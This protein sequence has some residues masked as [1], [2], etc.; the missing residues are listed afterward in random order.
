MPASVDDAAMQTAEPRFSPLRI[1]VL[2]AGTA[3]TLFF[4]GAVVEWWMIPHDRRDG[5]ELIGLLL[6]L[7]YFL[8]LA[9]PTLLL[10]YIGRWLPFAAAL[11]VVAIALATD[12]LRPWI[13]WP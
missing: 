11:G 1:F 10:G 6:A 4:V 2:L 5:F 3:G 9:M 7:A 8:V 13:P 12:T